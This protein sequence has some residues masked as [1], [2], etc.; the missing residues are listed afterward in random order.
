MTVQCKQAMAG[1][2]R[3]LNFAFDENR[4]TARGSHPA[5]FGVSAALRGNFP[6]SLGME[7]MT[8]VRRGKRR[9]NMLKSQLSQRESQVQEEGKEQLLRIATACVLYTFA[10][11]RP[12]KPSLGGRLPGVSFPSVAIKS[13]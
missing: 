10:V 3:S 13:L 4:L 12:R 9:N 11:R 2:R 1:R 7:S 8:Y 6:R 5:E